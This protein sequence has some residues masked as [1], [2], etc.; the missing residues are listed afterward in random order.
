VLH[1]CIDVNGGAMDER[2]WGETDVHGLTLLHVMVCQTACPPSGRLVFATFY[3]GHV[4]WE[5]GKGSGKTSDFYVAING[6]NAREKGDL[7]V[8][9]Q[10]E[11]LPGPLNDAGRAASRRPLRRRQGRS[12]ARPPSR[13]ELAA[14]SDSPK[15]A[16]ACLM[17]MVIASPP[18][19]G[20]MD[21]KQITY[22]RAV[23][24]EG[25][26]GRASMLLNIAQPAISTQVSS[27]ESE[28][29][30]TLFTRHPRGVTLTAAGAVFLEHAKGILASVEAARL[31]VR[32]LAETPEGLITIGMP[33]TIA[34]ILAGPL[35]EH[36]SLLLPK[37]EIRLI[38]ALSGEINSWHSSGR[39]DIA[40]LYAMHS[41]VIANALPLLDEQL[42]LLSPSETA[43]S[44]EPVRFSDLC[45]LPLFHTSRGHACRLL[46]DETASRTGVRLNYVAEIDSI[47]LLLDFVARKGGYT[48]FPSIAVPAA[49]SP[50]ARKGLR[51]ARERPS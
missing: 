15:S 25:S 29:G 41:R 47:A 48:I 35:I 12:A 14:S 10:I 2:K 37:V 46:L 5:H 32:E 50:P 36:I 19:A 18:Q 4:A 27:L 38:E 22:F 49:W 21:I 20:P 8:Q 13:L 3:Q 51:R 11:I 44:S 42:Y 28:L 31:A 9:A 7:K 1:D 16:G 34:N 39:F 26:I 24:Q 43:G 40:V 6:P 45:G 23:A 30:A 33:T 17:S